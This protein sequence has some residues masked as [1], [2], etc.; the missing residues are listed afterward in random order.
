MGAPRVVGAVVVGANGCEWPALHVD[1]GNPHAVAPVEDVVDAGPLTTPPAYDIRDFP[2]GVNVEF[3]ARRGRGRLAMRVF[4]RGVGET[5]S[6]GT[7]AC[8]AVA[9]AASV[10]DDPPATYQVEV[11]GGQLEVSRTEQG[12]V[13]TGPA[14]IVA[15]GQ[16]SWSGA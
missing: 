4:E 2:A 11:L 3:V 12:M 6:C 8:A 5:R 13:L 16:F 14:V 10:D 7:G 15:N 1:A 9:A